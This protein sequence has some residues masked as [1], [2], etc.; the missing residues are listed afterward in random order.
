M[1]INLLLLN[2]MLTNSAATQIVSHVENEFSCLYL[3]RCDYPH[4]MVSMHALQ[5]RMCL[6]LW[7]M[8]QIR[9]QSTG[10]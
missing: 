3:W 6:S 8:L 10:W 5:C 4:A 2:A 1:T 9:H 7:L